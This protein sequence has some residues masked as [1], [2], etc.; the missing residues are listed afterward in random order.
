MIHWKIQSEWLSHSE[1]LA[2]QSCHISLPPTVKVCSGDVWSSLHW[3]FFCFQ[4]RRVVVSR[5]S[6]LSASHH[7]TDASWPLTPPLFSYVFFSFYFDSSLRL[8]LTLSHFACAP[9]PVVAPKS[10]NFS[11][12]FTSLVLYFLPPPSATCIT[13]S[14]PADE[15]GGS[16]KDATS[17]LVKLDGAINSP[18]VWLAARWLQPSFHSTNRSGGAERRELMKIKPSKWNDQCSE[19]M[20]RTSATGL[21]TRIKVMSHGRVAQELYFDECTLQR[22]GSI[23][24]PS[25]RLTNMLPLTRSAACD[26]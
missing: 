8:L 22:W 7:R 21:F 5:L 24:A 23:I 17:P 6:A 9:R 14:L 12:E 13:P 1:K 10:L 19:V 2:Q 11:T 15:G 20:R 26:I 18:E 16:L 4:L 3:R 25:A